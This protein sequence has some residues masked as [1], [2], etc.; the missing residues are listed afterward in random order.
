MNKIL[1][2]FTLMFISFFSQ[3]NERNDN[4]SI[5]E[6]IS[7]Q[8][9]SKVNEPNLDILFKK[10][11]TYNLYRTQI[12]KPK[13]YTK[14]KFSFGKPKSDM[15]LV[16]KGKWI[17]NKIDN[18]V[19]IFNSEGQSFTYH[20]I[21]PNDELV[22]LLIAGSLDNANIKQSWVSVLDFTDDDPGYKGP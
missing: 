1:L 17:S 5:E 15:V 10:D 14:F 20:F 11:H 18:E 12:V 22:C 4:L 21:P 2:L 13:T 6:S 3:G 16:G 8:F 7:G 9:F 19:T